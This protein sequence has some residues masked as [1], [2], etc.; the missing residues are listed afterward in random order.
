MAINI[1]KYQHDDTLDIMT[2]FYNI[3]KGV[4]IRVLG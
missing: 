3:V 2:L 4:F 1:R